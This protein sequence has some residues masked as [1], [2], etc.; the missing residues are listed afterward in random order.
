MKAEQEPAK[1]VNTKLG[2]RRECTEKKGSGK[3]QGKM[4]T[5]TNV[6]GVSRV[7]ISKFINN[8]FHVLVMNMNNV[9]KKQ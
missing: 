9:K 8:V 2:K 3:L 6:Q 7:A 4:P 1:R 5:K